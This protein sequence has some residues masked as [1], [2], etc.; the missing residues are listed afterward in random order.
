MVPDRIEQVRL[1]QPHTAIDKERVVRLPRLLCDRH[2][3][4][5]GELVPG[6]DD[7]VLERVL[8]V[9]LNPPPSLGLGR[10]AHSLNDGLRL[11]RPRRRLLEHHE[12]HRHISPSACR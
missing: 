11:H 7:E 10:R 6:P 9:Q 8:Q 12:R 1:A 2:A 5:V 3:G 4:G